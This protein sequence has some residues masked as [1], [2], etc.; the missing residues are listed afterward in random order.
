MN[1]LPK[2]VITLIFLQLDGTDRLALLAAFPDLRINWQLLY[3]NEKKKTGTRKV[4][5]NVKYGG[6]GLSDKAIEMYGE[7]KGLNLQKRGS[8]YYYSDESCFSY[9]DISRE[10]PVLVDVVEKLGELSWWILAA[11]KIVEIPD[12]VDYTIEDYDGLEHI[13]E[14]HRTWNYESE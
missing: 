11:L 3:N 10:D 1:K 14:K 12:N 4:V 7:L 6:F 5:I 13:A 9:Y 8:R 2:D